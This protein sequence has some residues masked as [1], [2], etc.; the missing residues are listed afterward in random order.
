MAKKSL[1]LLVCVVMIASFC[2]VLTACND[3]EQPSKKIV[4]LGDS[5]A[6]AVLGA[7][8]LNEREYY[9]YY[10]LVGKTNNF[11]YIN[12]SVSGHQTG[13]LLKKILTDN[14]QNALRVTTHIKTADILH[15]SI[16]GNDML[17]DDLGALV[18]EQARY[19][20]GEIPALTK[21]DG[22]IRS[23]NGSRKNIEKIV[24]RLRELNPDAIIIFQTVYNP[25]HINTS[26]I[27][28]GETENSAGAKDILHSDYGYYANAATNEDGSLKYGEDGKLIYASEELMNADEAQLREL[29]GKVLADL[30]DSVRDYVA[31]HPNE[32]IYIADATKAFGDIWSADPVR[33]RKLIYPDDVHPSNEG[34][35]V[36]YG[37]TQQLLDELGLID[38]AKALKNYKKLKIE[39]FNRLFPNADKK[40]A[41][42]AINGATDYDGVTNAYF[43][44]AD[45]LLPSY[46]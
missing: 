17:Q 19:E 41:K 45:G 3:N 39:Q 28:R 34:H 7:S 29:C 22:I 35:A 2:C 1:V 5:I 38:S 8:P 24:A 27:H 42:K 9:G 32:N 15:I 43:R 16:L 40:A 11:E 12:R 20:R 44:A 14:D 13:Q 25:V 4:Y 36:M 37:V 18:L 10:A 46:C 30:N 21:R 6:E 23:E 31:A 26:L 33:G